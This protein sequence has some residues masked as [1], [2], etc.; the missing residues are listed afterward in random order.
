MCEAKRLDTGRRL[1][2]FPICTTNSTSRQDTS[3]RNNND[4]EE[5][6]NE[7]EARKTGLTGDSGS[8][9]HR[10]LKRPRT[11]RLHTLTDT[12][13]RGVKQRASTA[14]AQGRARRLVRGT[15]DK[16]FRQQRMKGD[17]E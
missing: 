6:R 15:A 16:H 5:P 3:A 17:K 1:R 8:R 9:S 7:V 12:H 4:H 14:T 10:L 11:L 2:V 13:H